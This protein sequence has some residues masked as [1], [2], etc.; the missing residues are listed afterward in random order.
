[1]ETIDAGCAVDC[2]LFYCLSFVGD[3]CFL[4]ILMSVILK[5]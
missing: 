5:L 2:L 1:M 3:F 4:Q